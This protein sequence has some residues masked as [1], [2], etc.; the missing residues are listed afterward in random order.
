MTVFSGI[1][2]SGDV[3]L[4]NYL[5]AMKNWVE[6]Q[7]YNAGQCLYSVVDQHSLTTCRNPIEL[8]KNTIDGF[9]LAMAIG[10][11]PTES[12]LF[13]QS[14]VK[15]HSEMW[16]LLNQYV[17]MGELSRMTQFK[18]KSRG[19]DG[20][21]IEAGL[22]NYPVLMAADI[23]L[24]KANLVAV[25]N[26]QEQHLQLA[27]QIVRKANNADRQAG[28]Q[29][30]A[31]VTPLVSKS[32]A[33]GRIMALQTPD[34]KMSKSD[35]NDSN[36]I[37]M[38]EDTRSVYQK[39]RLATVRVSED[40]LV[41][42]A[43]GDLGVENLLSIGACLWGTDV[44]LEN[45]SVRALKKDLAERV[46]AELEPIQKEFLRIRTDE[47]EVSRLMSLGAEK[48]QVIAENNLKEFKR[49]LG[50]VVI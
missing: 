35:M 14:H 8:R 6:L 41:G 34:K 39:L 9:V 18:D 19:E 48:A 31:F 15:E 4:G 20:G 11:D 50:F 7:S 17:P 24:Y 46:V 16:W 1:Q 5:G 3:T 2:P 47:G 10:I 28:G 30:D 29:G 33:G 21:K 40:A 25:G 44:C 42:E 32:V 26:D 23:L 37:K 12:T 45:L 36:V 49:N 38:L 13:I 43:R 22:F 27:R